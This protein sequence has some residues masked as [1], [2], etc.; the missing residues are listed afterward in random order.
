MEDVSGLF[1]CR[2]LRGPIDAARGG[3]SNKKPKGDELASKS[4]CM[5]FPI[6]KL[7]LVAALAAAWV[8][9]AHAA[10]PTPLT[11]VRAVGDLTNEEARHGLP[12]TVE[13][14]VSYFRAYER[15]LF[16]EDGGAAIYVKAT[17]D[18]PLAPGDR[19]AYA[20]AR[21]SYAEYAVAPAWQL[22]KIPGHVE[23][24]LAAAACT[25]FW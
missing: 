11:T 8:Y 17:T 18:L 1:Q 20:M 14:T 2:N 12:A 4:D 13:A 7:L 9:A 21:G 3:M 6:K 24:T 25:W 16:V 5:V 22:V 15:T 10:V 19:V 23:F